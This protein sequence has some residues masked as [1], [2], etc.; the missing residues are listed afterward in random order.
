MKQ[1]ED[2]NSLPVVS[3]LKPEVQSA[4]DV[5]HSE[6]LQELG[7]QVTL[8]LA[9]SGSKLRDLCVYIHNNKDTI[10]KKLVTRELVD[11]L[12]FKKAYVSQLCRVSFSSAKVFKPY[13][14]ARIGFH[15]AID[16]ARMDD[17]GKLL[18]VTPAARLLTDS[19][20]LPSEDADEIAAKEATPASASGSGT[21]TKSMSARLK[22]AAKFIA[23]NATRGLSYSFADARFRVVVEKI[24]KTRPALGDS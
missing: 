4:L 20:A 5:R 6:R 22:S 23:T 11:K 24:E 1:K 9:D 8:S 3:D 10:S 15:Q 14:A 12:G 19:G 7:K 17:K 21:G 16:F 2:S 18:G 13:E